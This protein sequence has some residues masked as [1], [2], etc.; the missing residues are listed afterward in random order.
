M[1]GTHLCGILYHMKEIPSCPGY[2]A[3][4]DGNVFSLYF[5]RPLQEEIVTKSG[6][7]RVQVRI[8][9]KVHHRYVHR[10]IC[11]AF[12]GTCPSGKQCS[13]LDGN[14]SNNKPENLL[15][16]TPKENTNRKRKHGTMNTFRKLTLNEVEQIIELLK[17]NVRQCD[18]AIQ[19]HI[20]QAH[21]SRIKLDHK[22]LDGISLRGHRLTVDQY[23][24]IYKLLDEGMYQKD[25]AKIFG[26]T[27]SGI[28]RI[29]KRRKK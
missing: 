16:E 20:S 22:D 11:E 7:H 5:K 14:R 21:V 1:T 19:F 4:E 10:L 29:N 27:Q 12:N 17:Q 9:G 15:W 8:N 25:V 2:L 28:Y 3:S 18:I 23:K 13:H 24:E 6:Y 26:L